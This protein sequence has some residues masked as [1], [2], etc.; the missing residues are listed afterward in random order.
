AVGRALRETAGPAC[1]RDFKLSY[2][3]RSTCDT[4]H[5][6]NSPAASTA[7]SHSSSGIRVRRARVVRHC[8][9]RRWS[10]R[11][12]A[13]I[14]RLPRASARPAVD[15]DMRGDAT[16]PPPLDHARLP[17][18]HPTPTRA[19]HPSPDFDPACFAY[20]ADDAEVTT[21]TDAR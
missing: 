18:G 19:T 2:L 4:D 16:A 7:A 6:P 11:N 8:S 21:A 3:I 5:G 14:S 10:G 13:S 17:K 9:I 12:A 20:P 1:S 15:L